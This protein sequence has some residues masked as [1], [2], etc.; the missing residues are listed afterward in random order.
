[1]TEVP[2]SGFVCELWCLS[3]VSLVVALSLLCSFSE[4][5]KSE[6]QP[7]ARKTPA[8]D[9]ALVLYDSGSSGSTQD[10]H[11]SLGKPIKPVHTKG[12]QWNIQWMFNGRTEAEAPVLWLPKS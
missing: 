10:I 7:C 6:N 11:L 3:L 4:S 5:R 9:D 2:V 12:N 1:M 8:A